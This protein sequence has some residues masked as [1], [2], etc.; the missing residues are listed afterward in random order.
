MLASTDHLHL[1][2]HQYHNLVRSSPSSH[3]DFPLTLSK[4]F[5]TRSLFLALVPD[6]RTQSVQPP[7][8]AFLLLDIRIISS[9]RALDLVHAT[10]P[11][12]LAPFSG[13]GGRE[14]QRACASCANLW[15]NRIQAPMVGK[16]ILSRRRTTAVCRTKLSGA[17]VVESV[18]GEAGRWRRV[19]ARRHHHGIERP[20][21]HAHRS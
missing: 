18:S 14:S 1:Y 16:I 21:W 2:Q 11:R 9:Q 6:T 10:P 12:A 13:H 3:V 15:K 19:N 5:E 8:T 20:Q 17:T 4:V 7:E